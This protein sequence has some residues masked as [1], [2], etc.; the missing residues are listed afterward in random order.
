[1]ALALVRA[2]FAPPA[3]RATRRRPRTQ[4]VIDALPDALTSSQRAAR[5]AIAGDL[6]QPVRMQR[7]CR[8][9]RLRPKT[10]VARWRAGSRK[11]ASRRPYGADRNLAPALK[12][13]APLA[14]RAGLNAA[15]LTAARRARSA[16][17][18]SP[19]RCR[20]IDLVVAHTR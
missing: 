5:A 17:I 14:A 12:T 10:V 8:V 7:C 6:Q 2:Q 13:I 3:S 11:P 19:S 4:Q 20:E 18:F 15:I 1:L 16:A 9:T